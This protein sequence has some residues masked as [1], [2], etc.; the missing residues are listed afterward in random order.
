[1]FFFSNSQCLIKG[2][3]SSLVCG[4]GFDATCS[5]VAIDTDGCPVTVSPSHD[6]QRNIILWKDH[7]AILEA[8]EINK[9]GHP[10]LNF[11]GGAISP[12][13]EPPKLLWLKRNLP[14][15]C[16]GRACHFFDLADYLV[17]RCTGVPTR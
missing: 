14:N 12:E 11:V 10:V 1:M 17:Y 4:I 8:D 9:S 13:M 6:S 15:E 7:R 16:W 2:V 5:L 3:D